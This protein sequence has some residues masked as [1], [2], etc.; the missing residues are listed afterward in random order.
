MT[1]PGNALNFDGSN[2]YVNV[3]DVIEGFAAITFE[4]WVYHVGEWNL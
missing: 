2:H 3:G 4:A 1:P